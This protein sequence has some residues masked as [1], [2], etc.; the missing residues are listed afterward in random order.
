M[1]LNKRLLNIQSGAA[2]EMLAWYKFDGNANDSSGNGYNATA[3]NVS[4]VTGLYSNAASFN[5][6]SSYTTFPTSN[7]FSGD[8]VSFSFWVNT[9]SD[10]EMIL[11]NYG[12]SSSASRFNFW[13][14]GSNAF[15]IE[16]YQ[17]SNIYSRFFSDRVYS[18]NT[19]HHV[20]LIFDSA[21]F[22]YPNIMKLYVNGT[23]DPLI[24]SSTQGTHTAHTILDNSLDLVMGK[25]Y[26]TNDSYFS[27]KIDQFRIYNYALS[28]AEVTSLY[29]E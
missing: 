4:Y 20:V 19:W 9:A 6:S 23:E 11:T 22:S 27:G 26:T 10:Y 25:R 16:Y 3:T 1:G 2:E 15:Y 13:I 21:D 24:A 8:A 7:N 18:Y 28:S 29:N 12:D 5:G 17:T 14:F